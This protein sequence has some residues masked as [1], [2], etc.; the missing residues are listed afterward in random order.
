MKFEWYVTFYATYKGFEHTLNKEHKI[1]NFLK[2]CELI[3][4]QGHYYTA[5]GT[6]WRYVC[7]KFGG[8]TSSCT[9][10]LGDIQKIQAHA[11]SMDGGV[12]NLHVA[13]NIKFPFHVGPWM[14]AP[15]LKNCIQSKLSVAFSHFWLGDTMGQYTNLNEKWCWSI[16]KV[17]LFSNLCFK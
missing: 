3:T 12:F 11:A 17:D 1:I 10:T 7:V 8:I 15:G 16:R 6:H 14:L 13:K 9:W 5:V 4:N 2:F